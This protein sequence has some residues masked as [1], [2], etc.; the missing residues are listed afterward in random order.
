VSKWKRGCL[1]TLI[2]GPVLLYVLFSQIL[3]PSRVVRYQLTVDLVTDDGQHHVGS[4]VWQV[5]Y[6][7]VSDL[8]TAG[9][10]GNLRG[11]VYADAIPIQVSP[12]NT[13]WIMTSHQSDSSDIERAPRGVHLVRSS[14]FSLLLRCFDLSGIYYYRTIFSLPKSGAI[15]HP[16]LK[17]LPQ[18][19]L[20][21]ETDQGFR[22]HYLYFDAGGYEHQSGIGIAS[23]AIEVTRSPFTD[24]LESIERLGF[25][26]DAIEQMK[27][28]RYDGNF[29]WSDIKGNPIPD[30]I[31]MSM[32]NMRGD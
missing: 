24:N 28:G 15:C 21:T 6:Y 10:G 25:S 14:P 18:M 9:G 13:V 12:K 23:A 27:K 32:R 4:G 19:Y 16:A 29:A 2:L 30:L 31:T 26:S 11:I 3:Y 5:E 17:N 7:V 22:F 8:L 20:A 1:G